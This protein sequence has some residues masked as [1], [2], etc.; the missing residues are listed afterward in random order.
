VG[1]Y[2][3]GPDLLVL[4]GDEHGR[5]P[6]QLQVLARDGV[7]GQEA[8]DDVGGEEQ[9]LGG[10]LELE[11]HLHQPVHQD[12]AHLVVDVRLPRHVLRAHAALALRAHTPPQPSVRPAPRPTLRRGRKGAWTQGGQAPMW[13]HTNGVGELLQ[14]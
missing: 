5:D 2:L 3:W 6:H 13:G 14:G 1:A 4:G 11:V 7:E 9:R 8:V 12:G 10:E